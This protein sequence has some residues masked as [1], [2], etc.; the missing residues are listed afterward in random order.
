MVSDVPSITN[1]FIVICFS[2]IGKP[3]NLNVFLD[4]FITELL[5]LLANGIKIGSKTY[6]V[7]VYEII[8]DA[9]ARS[10]IKCAV[11]HNGTKGFERCS[12]PAKRL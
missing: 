2:G 12:Q 10:F 3:P 1:P 11:G 9:P 6:P 4:P 7:K 8:C 5:D